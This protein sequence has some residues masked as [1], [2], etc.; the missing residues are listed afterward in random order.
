MER[1]AEE[2]AR[3]RGSRMEDS[4]GPVEG[5]RRVGKGARRRSGESHPTAESI[6]RYERYAFAM[7]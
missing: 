7:R 4:Q 6:D 1:A 2:F 3:A 5:P